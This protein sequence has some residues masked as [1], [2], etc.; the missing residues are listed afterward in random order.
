VVFGGDAEQATAQFNAQC[1]S[2][3][4][5]STPEIARQKA[6]KQMLSRLAAN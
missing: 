1:D 3:H 5:E 2:N 4:F 6:V